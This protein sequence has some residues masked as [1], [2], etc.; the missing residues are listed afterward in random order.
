MFGF[1]VPTVI[2]KLQRTVTWERSWA[3]SYTNQLKDVHE[4]DRVTNGTW[5]ELDIALNQ[6]YDV[7]IPRLLGVL[8]SEGHEITP[9][10]VHGGL[11]DNNV[12]TDMETGDMIIFDPGC[13][14]SHN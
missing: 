1:H 4:Y 2:G 9:V 6:L 8:Q 10:L 7:V 5:R 11:W 12:G 13:T 14:Y 3:A